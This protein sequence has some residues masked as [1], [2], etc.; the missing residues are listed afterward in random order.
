MNHSR[1]YRTYR[2]AQVKLVAVA[3]IWDGEMRDWAVYCGLVAETNNEIALHGGKLNLEQAAP[4]FGRAV[5]PDQR[6]R[7]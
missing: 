5:W 1:D 7:A 2:V 4:F 3:N 6:Y